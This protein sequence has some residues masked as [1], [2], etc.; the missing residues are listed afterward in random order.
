MGGL[1]VYFFVMEGQGRTLEEI[2]TMY[3]TKVI[4]WKSNKW[5]A[6]LPSEMAKIRKQAGTHEDGELADPK[7]SDDMEK[8]STELG[9]AH[10]R[11]TTS[12]TTNGNVA[13]NEAVNKE[14]N[15]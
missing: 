8:A 2:D 13:N 15:I 9:D 12:G 14:G 6:P 1:L 10:D 7:V 4:P 5:V 3:L 11:A